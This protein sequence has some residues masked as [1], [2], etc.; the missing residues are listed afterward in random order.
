[1]GDSGDA[2]FSIAFRGPAVENGD[3]D[4]R[5]LAPALLALGDLIQESNKVINGGNISAIVKV[6]ATERGCFEVSFV[7]QHIAASA[8][9]ILSWLTEN[10]EQIVVGNQLLDLILK[11]F[12]VGGT[13]GGGVF[14]LLKWLRNRKPDKVE[15]IAGDVHIHIGD[16][17]FVTNRQVLKLAEHVPVRRH[18]EKFVAVLGRGG[19]DSISSKVNGKEA[20]ALVKDDVPSFALPD[21]DTQEELLNEIRKMNLQIISLTFKDDGKW[22]FTDGLEPFAASI[23]DKDF[24]KR[25][26]ANEVVFGEG[27]YLI[28]EV[29]E[30]QFQTLKGL[31]TERTIV[32]ILEHKPGMRQLNLF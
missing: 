8:Q 23:E 18:A 15:T 6:R 11:T 16:Q 27:D 1:M 5:D 20:V 17:Y 4:V 3:I 10:K 21:Q 12:G 14:A 19:I 30:H 31:K 13:I 7:L 9:T 24:Q 2:F 29:R 26:H 32:K 25:I 22:R 28:C